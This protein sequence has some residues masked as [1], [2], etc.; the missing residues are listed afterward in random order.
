MS[1]LSR[2]LHINIGNRSEAE[3][4]LLEIGSALL[5]DHGPDYGWSQVTI[6]RIPH[7][8]TRQ[9]IAY[10]AV[11]TKRL[12]R[13]VRWH[14]MS[15]SPRQWEE[16]LVA[17]WRHECPVPGLTGGLAYVSDKARDMGVPHCSEVIDLAEEFMAWLGLTE[18]PRPHHGVAAA[19]PGDSLADLDVRLIYLGEGI[20]RQGQPQTHLPVPTTRRMTSK[21]ERGARHGGRGPWGRVCRRE[22]VPM[23]AMAQCNQID[24]ESQQTSITEE[25]AIHVSS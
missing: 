11:L 12:S 13:H 17:A 8:A 7:Q 1:S 5:D 19:Q 10:L 18:T 14:G 24:D 9:Q 23:A 15:L 21:I 2:T 20:D 6:S 25:G 16:L 22:R 3:L 4:A